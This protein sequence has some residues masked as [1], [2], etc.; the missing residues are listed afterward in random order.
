MDGGQTTIIPLDSDLDIVAQDMLVPVNAPE[1]L[2]NRQKFTGRCLPSSVRFEHDGWAAGNYVYNYELYK[3]SVESEPNGLIISYDLLSNVGPVYMLSVVDADGRSVGY[4]SIIRESNNA[5]DLTLADTGSN[6]SITGTVNNKSIHLIFNSVTGVV[7]SGATHS[8]DVTFEYSVDSSGKLTLVLTDTTST[9]TLRVNSMR[10]ASNGVLGKDQVMAFIEYSNG[11]YTWQ[12]TSVDVV[13]DGS[14]LDITTNNGTAV[15]A[16]VDNVS[17]GKDGNIAGSIS[18]VFDTSISLDVTTKEFIYFF[19]LRDAQYN[20]MAQMLDNTNQLTAWQFTSKGIQG[21]TTYPSSKYLYKNDDAD[22]QGQVL[23]LIVPIWFRIKVTSLINGLTGAVPSTRTISATYNGE[24]YYF[25]INGHIYSEATGYPADIHAC[26]GVFLSD[27]DFQWNERHDSSGAA[28]DIARGLYTV[29]MV[30]DYAINVNVPYNAGTDDDSPT[31]RYTTVTFNVPYS[32]IW[33]LV[34]N[35]P[36]APVSIQ[37]NVVGEGGYTIR[38]YFFIPSHLA[39][40]IADMSKR[41]FSVTCG[42]NSLCEGLRFTATTKID[43]NGSKR[44]TITSID[45]K[46]PELA[47]VGS[48]LDY[49][50][51]KKDDNG[52]EIGRVGEDMPTDTISVCRNGLLSKTITLR[53]R[54]GTQSRITSAFIRNGIEITQ[55]PTSP[56]TWYVDRGKY[57]WFDMSVDIETYGDGVKLTAGLLPGEHSTL[58]W[59]NGD[60]SV[61]VPAIDAT[62]KSR[63]GVKVSQCTAVATCSCVLAINDDRAI[64]AVSRVICNNDT[65]VTGIID[66]DKLAS[67]VGTGLRIQPQASTG[68]FTFT[69]PQHTGGKV[70]FKQAVL[71]TKPDGTVVTAQNNGYIDEASWFIPIT[72]T[73]DS[74]E[75]KLQ[76]TIDNDIYAYVATAKAVVPFSSRLPGSTDSAYTLRGAVGTNSVSVAST[77]NTTIVTYADGGVTATADNATIVVPA[78]NVTTADGTV[79]VDFAYVPDYEYSMYPKQVLTSSVAVKTLTTEELVLSYNDVDYSVNLGVGPA[80]LFA[81]GKSSTMT[82]NSVDV[83]DK[84]AQRTNILTIDTSDMYQFVRQAWDCESSTRTFWYIDENRYLRLTRDKLV[85]M[86]KV[87]GELHDWYGDVWE[88]DRSW[89]RQDILWPTVAQYLCSSAYNS[90]PYIVTLTAKSS[91]EFIL[92]LFDTTSESDQLS[93]TYVTVGVETVALGDKLNTNSTSTGKLTIKSYTAMNVHD[94]CSKATLSATRIDDLVIVGIHYN[95]NFNQWAI[96]INVKT[97]QRSYIQGYGYVGVD[98]S[99]TGGEIPATC[100]SVSDGGFNNIVYPLSVLESTTASTA[101]ADVSATRDIVVGDATQQWYLYSKLDGIVSHLTYKNGTFTP[102]VLPITN[103]YTGLYA[104]GSASGYNA[105]PF[106]I[107]RANAND[108]GNTSKWSACVSA[109]GS[110]GIYYSSP[111]TVACAYLQQ[112]C[113]QAAY[114]HYNSTNGRKDVDIT[115]KSSDAAL[116]NPTNDAADLRDLSPLSSDTLAFDT[117]TI[118]QR[119][120]VKAST[121]ST[122]ALQILLSMATT[123]VDSFISTALQVNGVVSMETTNDIAK[124]YGQMFAHNTVGAIISGISARSVDPGL[125]SQVTAVKSLDMFYS[126]SDSQCV[127]AGPGFVSHSFVAQCTAQSVTSLQYESYA[128]SITTLYPGISKLEAMP[129]IIALRVVANAAENT[130]QANLAPSLVGSSPGAQVSPGYYVALGAAVVLTGAQSALEAILDNL[131]AFTSTLDVLASKGPTSSL[132]GQAHTKNYDIEGKHKY[133]SKSEMFMW[134]CFDC[135]SFSIPDE[136]VECVA[137]TTEVELPYE[138]SNLTLGPGVRSNGIDNVTKQTSATFNNNIV[139][140]PYYTGMIKGATTHRKLPGNT[141]YVIGT[142]DF[143]SKAPFR[144]ENISE[145]EPVF[146]IPI[147]HDYVIDKRWSLGLTSPG[148]GGVSWVSCKDTKVI[149]GAPSNIVVSDSFCGIACAYAAIEVKRGIDG[150]YVRPWA[151]TPQAV[152]FNQTGNNCCAD[153]EVLHACDGYGYRLTSWLGG[154]GMHKEH[155]SLLYCYIQNE[156]FKLSNKLPPNQF[157]GNFN[158]EPVTAVEVS[159]GRDTVYTL[160]TQPNRSKGTVS[161]QMGEDK[162]IIR[163]SIPIF[164]EQVSLLPAAVKTY[165]GYMLSV[166]EGIT[167]LVTDLRTDMNGYKI[168]VSEDFTVGT[169][170]YRITSEYIC[171]V[172]NERGVSVMDNLVPALG[173]RFL[174][175]TPHEAYFYSQAT[176]LYYVYTGGD[177]LNAVTSTERFRDIV[178]GTYDFVSQEVVV[179]ALATFNRLDKYVE[180]DMDETD[181]IIVPRLKNQR[182]IG[183]ISPPLATICNT[184]S[185]YRLMSLPVGVTYQGP[186]RCII[187]QFLVSDYMLSGILRNKGKWRRV[188]REKYNPMRRYS[189]IYERVDKQL[190]NAMMVRG[191]THNPFLLV[192]APIGLSQET[193]CLFEWVITFCWTVEMDKLVAQNEYICVN[194]TSETMSPG[195][196]K[197][198]ERPTHIFLSKELFTRSDNYG[199]YSF[200]YSGQTGAGNRERLHIWSDGFIAVSSLAIEYKPITTRRNEVLTQQVDVI[201]RLVEM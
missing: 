30:G 17:V 31:I 171:E 7:S 28:D 144:N 23:E 51:A 122:N 195:G 126:T 47:Y 117:V 154:N 43:S 88:E 121:P 37:H 172:K 131:A 159:G 42:A 70:D 83:Y 120:H 176:R 168:P 26:E 129:A 38:A 179:P 65:R 138:Y 116:R 110:P 84:D 155:M 40:I 115:T 107:K 196:K 130:L 91:N 105:E 109:I 194:I 34:E 64:G 146:P 165:S 104:S 180:D 106:N 119:T 29:S 164:T 178:H 151:V 170:T 89:Q 2:H 143:L 141:A 4:I 60:S 127:H 198:A 56:N 49:A 162:D 136:T 139:K 92:G 45:N 189:S 48:H 111:V 191:W 96:I 128:R 113:V 137:T 114:T 167:G 190:D 193:D 54:L 185:W 33:W 142:S 11:I 149:D 13:Y 158:T 94:L 103:T 36:G 74:V 77:D 101:Y 200:R 53:E 14:V 25:A 73:V 5:S 197:V 24:T 108:L 100:F 145:S 183:E 93:S 153:N 72:T 10:L 61:W 175:S 147:I 192:T 102:E 163:Y 199:Y 187:N 160:L 118:T 20:Y 46:P 39:D 6:V 18:V 124:Q 71:I 27:V 87:V 135:D 156:R 97:K 58:Y 32:M 166:I 82:F 75:F 125:M 188:P 152:L 78:D 184:R 52:N 44:I 148:Y 81:P 35:Y 22:S 186:N 181:N 169:R 80:G 12:D 98:G 201:G 16:T 59:Y 68:K 67:I 21:D 69:T 55:G 63:F 79:S 99:L 9:V 150:R 1:F 41:D 50:V 182:F 132:L 15:D 173:L 57:S 90:T 157:L 177:R 3:H 112:T 8:G 133:G 134:P 123:S 86:R 62:G 19:L 140:L 161:G 66:V 174:G 76:P 85:R 95:N